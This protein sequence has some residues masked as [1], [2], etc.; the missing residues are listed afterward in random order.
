LSAL[1]F[2]DHAGFKRTLYV[3]EQGTSIGNVELPPPAP[4]TAFDVRFA[5]NAYVASLHGSGRQEFP[6]TLQSTSYP[7][8]I[9][10]TLTPGHPH[11]ILSAGPTMEELG[12]SGALT[13]QQASEHLSLLA[14]APMMVAHPKAY[15]MYQN[16]PNP[17]NP[18]TEI[19]YELPNNSRV[20]L[21]VLNTLGETVATLVDQLQT[22]GEYRITW[23][24]MI[25]SGV[26]FYRLEATS[27]DNSA[28]FYQS[29]MKAIYLK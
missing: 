20:R 6:I 5:P 9:S 29:I 27:L 4:E 2:E 25:A 15:A 21:T 17:F 1:T 14:G 3:N 16:Y 8:T 23:N 28:R 22:E 12:E 24:P 18:S 7:V 10:W 26:Y 13:L 11:Y 19:R